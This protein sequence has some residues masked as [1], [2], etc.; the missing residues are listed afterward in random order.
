MFGVGCPA[1]VHVKVSGFP[2]PT[3]VSH[4]V[5]LFI[6]GGA[7]TH[8]KKKHCHEKRLKGLTI[9]QSCCGLTQIWT[10][11][12]NG[13]ANTHIKKTLLLKKVKKLFHKAMVLSLW[14][15][16]SLAPCLSFTSSLFCKGMKPAFFNFYALLTS[17]TLHHYPWNVRS[18]SV[19]Q[20]GVLI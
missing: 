9:N 1:E 19:F 4:D 2:F 6:V 8:I 5:V 15:L 18:L 16:I 7:N 10:R 20:P 3:N 17:F 12:E 13:G 11:G 14:R